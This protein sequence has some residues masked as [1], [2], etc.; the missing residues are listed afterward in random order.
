MVNI[1]QLFPHIFGQIADRLGI[2]GIC[3]LQQGQFRPNFG[4]FAVTVVAVVI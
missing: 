2:L 1:I 4:Q 3:P